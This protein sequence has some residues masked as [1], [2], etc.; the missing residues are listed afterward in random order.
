MSAAA[1]FYLLKTFYSA[2]VPTLALFF[3]K[4]LS[5]SQCVNGAAANMFQQSAIGKFLISVPTQIAGS[6]QTGWPARIAL[7]RIDAMRLIV[8]HMMATV[9]AGLAHD[10]AEI[11]VVVVPSGW[12]CI[13]P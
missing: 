10:S 8:G 6:S 1:P 4:I 12:G 5:N 7:K 3:A 11:R 13:F 2:A 9:R